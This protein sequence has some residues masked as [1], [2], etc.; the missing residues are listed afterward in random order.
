MNAMQHCVCELKPSVH[1]SEKLREKLV[2]V[3]ENRE[4]DVISAGC[5]KTE[6]AK[7]HCF[8]LIKHASVFQI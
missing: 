1:E 8:T 3:T 6:K 2:S 7:V 5:T 4:A